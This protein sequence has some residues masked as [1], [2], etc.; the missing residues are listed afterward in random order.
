MEIGDTL[1]LVATSFN[2]RAYTDQFG[3]SHDGRVVDDVQ[4]VTI[5]KKRTDVPGDY[6]SEPKY[7]GYIAQDAQGREYSLAWDYYPEASMD[8]PRWWGYAPSG[9]PFWS[10]PD[11]L[12][13]LTFRDGKRAEFDGYT[14]CSKHTLYHKSDKQCFM[15]QYGDR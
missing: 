5:T 15:C 14:F 3:I 9:L 2:R 12:Y 11:E 4:V 7:T 10:K 13:G 1:T 6:S 8:G